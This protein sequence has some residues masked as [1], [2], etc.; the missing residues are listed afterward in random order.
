MSSNTSN[1]TVPRLE[2][3][4]NK[5]V[6]QSIDEFHFTYNFPQDVPYIPA[7]NEIKALRRKLIEEEVAELFE[8]M[9]KDNKAEILKELVDVVVV[10]VGMADTYGWEF[11]EAFRRVHRSNMSKVDEDGQTQYREDGKL[12]KG[13]RYVP[14]FLRDLVGTFET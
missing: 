4:L 10:C 3:L 6:G 8:A 7:T 11:D 2:K 13:H 9:D 5:S 14:P 12:L 1:K